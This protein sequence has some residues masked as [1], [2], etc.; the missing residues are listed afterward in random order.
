MW[1]IIL[2]WSVGLASGF[3]WK[4][5]PTL[6]HQQEVGFRGMGVS[7][8]SAG[9]VLLKTDS[10]IFFFYNICVSLKMWLKEMSHDCTVSQNS[11]SGKR[12]SHFCS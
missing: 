10:I 4:P 9:I 3:C 5:D 12:L 2:A 11:D 1:D 7:T 8:G 6:L